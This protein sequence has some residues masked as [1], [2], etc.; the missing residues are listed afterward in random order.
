MEFREYATAT[1]GT[2]PTPGSA[3]FQVHTVHTE[4][5]RA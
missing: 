2:P 3:L 4:L 5:K 1:I